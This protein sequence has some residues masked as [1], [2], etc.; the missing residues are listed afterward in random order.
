ML[1]FLLVAAVSANAQILILKSTGANASAQYK[2]GS[3][4]AEDTVI[5]LAKGDQIV[6]L[7]GQTTRSID[8]PASITPAEVFTNKPLSGKFDALVDFLKNPSEE[9]V[10]LGAVRGNYVES[11]ADPWVVNVT[12]P[13]VK[14]VIENESLVLWR[15]MDITGDKGK[16]STAA[17]ESQ[18]TFDWPPGY[19]EADWPEDFVWSAGDTFRI[20][21]GLDE[22]IEFH[23]VEMPAG[24]VDNG[25]RI[26]WLAEQGCFSQVALLLEKL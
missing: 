11:P 13:G 19:T 12:T 6:I 26:V 18:T 24:I 21:Y 1:L 23:L 2:A 5:E 4:I 9:H 7:S 17:G 14:C 22:Q 8:G 16:L 10:V 3:V 25:S 15:G 20:D